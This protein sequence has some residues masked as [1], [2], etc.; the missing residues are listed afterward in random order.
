MNA[1]QQKTLNNIKQQVEEF[2][3]EALLREQWANT[4][5][6]S[7]QR[8]DA[9]GELARVAYNF[10]DTGFTVAIYA[11]D[12]GVPS[13]RGRS[14]YFD[15]HM[16]YSDTARYADFCQRLSETLRGIAPQAPMN[17]QQLAIHALELM[18][19][20]K[21]DADV[22]GAIA[23]VQAVAPNASIHQLTNAIRST[24]AAVVV[25]TAEELNGAAV[26]DVQD[27][28]VPRGWEVIE[29][30]VGLPPYEQG[31]DEAD[32]PAPAM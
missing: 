9:V 12:K 21:P 14:D 5:N 11:A 32:A 15:F 6:V 13:Q 25:F 22:D 16:S 17:Q 7:I 19:G 23:W 31:E 10:Q 30:L 18:R 20:K 28:L 2:G 29:D 24:G 26:E 3:L 4:G 27:V 1:V 8:K